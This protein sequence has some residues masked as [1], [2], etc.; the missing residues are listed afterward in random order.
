MTTVHL[1]LTPELDSFITAKIESGSYRDATQVVQAA[2][3]FLEREERDDEAKMMA[4]ITAVDAGEASGVAAGDV[5]GR[6]R[7]ARELRRQQSV[8]RG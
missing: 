5:F 6:V 8:A 7:A 1:D 3:A 2:L 4:V